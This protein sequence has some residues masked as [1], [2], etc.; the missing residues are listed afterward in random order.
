MQ[1]GDMIQPGDIILSLGSYRTSKL[2]ASLTEEE[3]EYWSHAALIVAVSPYPLIVQAVPP[4]VECRLLSDLVD[5]ADKVLLLHDK[6]LTD[7]ERAI[8]VWEGMKCVGQLYGIDR[9]PGLLLDELLN[10]DWFGDRWRLSREAPV[11]SVLVAA[12]R[13]KLGKNFGVNAQGA[14][15]SEIGAF[16]LI[17]PDVYARIA[18]K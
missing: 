13:D 1:S 17:H 8:V 9:F 6:S 5:H 2:I 18:I 4:R 3:G 12:G 15:P 16:S 14:T 7:H 11:C 10:T